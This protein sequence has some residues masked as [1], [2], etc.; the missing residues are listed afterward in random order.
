MGRKLSY[1]ELT[2]YQRIVVAVRET[3]RI[4]GEIDGVIEEHGAWPTQ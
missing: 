1:D 3:I 4:S 2:H